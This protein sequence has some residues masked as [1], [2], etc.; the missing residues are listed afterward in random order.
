[1]DDVELEHR[2][3]ANEKLAGSNRHRLDA[4]EERQGNLE[5]LVSA[6]DVL[7]NRQ[8][9]VET[10]VKEIKADVKVLTEKPGKRWDGIVDKLIWA[11]LAA[12]LGFV[13]AR[14]G[15]A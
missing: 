5:K 7:A 15:I 13:L 14:I 10:D 1:M 2:L 11:V 9:T 8:E 3:T 12:V 4:G 6:V